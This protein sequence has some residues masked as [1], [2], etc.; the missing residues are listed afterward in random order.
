MEQWR[1]LAGIGGSGSMIWLEQHG[2]GKTENAL[3]NFHMVWP[4][5]LAILSS[6]LSLLQVTGLCSVFQQPQPGSYPWFFALALTSAKT[7][8]LSECPVPGLSSSFRSLLLCHLLEEHTLFPT[9]QP[10]SASL[11]LSRAEFHQ[12][13]QV[14]LSSWH[15]SCSE[16]VSPTRRMIHKSRESHVIFAAML[17]VSRT[18]VNTEL[19]FTQ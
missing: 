2:K 19:A 7:S 14:F 17:E 1:R 10:E 11:L 18:A 13:T 16:T 4:L 9:T 3:I 15:L 12:L 6:L 8:S 5:P